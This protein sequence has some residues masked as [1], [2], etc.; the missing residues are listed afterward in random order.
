MTPVMVAPADVLASLAKE[1]F[2]KP[3]KPHWSQ[4]S[5][6][7]G[8]IA[9]EALYGADMFGKYASLDNYATGELELTKTELKL[10][11][12]LWRL[13][14]RCQPVVE[15]EHWAFVKRARALLLIEV[16]DVGKSWNV[17]VIT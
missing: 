11:L 1:A 6:I 4:Q 17:S 7:L 13:I 3:D 12:K 5:A 2:N 15:Y 14:Q 10:A 8:R 16:L 9:D